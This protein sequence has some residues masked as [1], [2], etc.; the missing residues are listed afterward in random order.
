M[1]LVA[2]ETR[3]VR[4]ATGLV[5]INLSLVPN[6]FFGNVKFRLARVNEKG[7]LAT[8]AILWQHVG[9]LSYKGGNKETRQGYDIG[10]ASFPGAWERG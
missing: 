1:L 6:F 2:S 7:S 10:I 5:S 3:S 4:A 8:I 9:V